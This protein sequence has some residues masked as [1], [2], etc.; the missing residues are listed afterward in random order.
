MYLYR[1]SF[2]KFV[3][4]ISPM[5]TKS[6]GTPLCLTPEERNYSGDRINDGAPQ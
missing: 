2:R 3:I 5:R 6:L 4:V 1:A